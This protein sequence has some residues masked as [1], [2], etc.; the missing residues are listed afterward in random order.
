LD[1]FSEALDSRVEKWKVGLM[2]GWTE[3]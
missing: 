1:D 3:Q 2:A